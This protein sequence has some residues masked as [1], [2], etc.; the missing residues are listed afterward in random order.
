MDVS[1]IAKYG[2]IK[3]YLRDILSKIGANTI[4]ITQRKL[5]DYWS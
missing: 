3:L 2:E 5:D 1:V 4:Y